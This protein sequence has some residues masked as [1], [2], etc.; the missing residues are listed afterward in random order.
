MILSR[1]EIEIRLSYQVA[2]LTFKPTPPIAPLRKMRPL[3]D[4]LLRAVG[5]WYMRYYPPSPNLTSNPSNQINWAIALCWQREV[6]KTEAVRVG[7][8]L[9]TWFLVLI[10]WLGM[11]LLAPGCDV[12]CPRLLNIGADL[13][14]IE[15]AAELK[16][17]HPPQ[18]NSREREKERERNIIRV[19]NRPQMNNMLHRSPSL[20]PPATRR[21]D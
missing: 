9:V 2:D 5:W 21:L 7:Q 4:C 20:P 1:F 3:Q 12:P 19:G 11:G 13:S 10:R 14:L 15:I 17:C 8:Y 16:A 18:L 6:H